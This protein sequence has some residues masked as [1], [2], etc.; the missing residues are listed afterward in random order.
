MVD[1]GRATSRG[2]RVHGEL[3]EEK[4]IYFCREGEEINWPVVSK[5]L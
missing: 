4:S 1:E 3:E 5:W 2:S